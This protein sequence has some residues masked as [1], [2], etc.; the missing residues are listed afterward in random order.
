MATKFRQFAQLCDA[1]QST[2]K[3]NEKKDLIAEFLLRLEHNEI[4][5]SV[6]FLIGNPKSDTNSR[7]LDIGGM[8]LWR[9]NPSRLSQKYLE[10]YF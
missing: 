8:P 7:P 4:A 10:I 5:P 9:L 1:P 6:S 3:R 2:S